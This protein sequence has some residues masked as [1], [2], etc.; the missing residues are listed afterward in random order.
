MDPEITLNLGNHVGS[1]RKL[2]AYWSYEAEQ[3]FSLWHNSSAC[4][5]T[6]AEEIRKEIQRDEMHDL[7]D[8]FKELYSAI[9]EHPIIGTLPMVDVVYLFDKNPLHGQNYS[10]EDLDKLLQIGSKLRLLQIGLKLNAI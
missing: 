7:S 5:D 3:D 4:A 2:K 10:E 9:L 1:P 8:A 6:L